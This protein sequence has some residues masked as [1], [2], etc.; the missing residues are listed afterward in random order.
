MTWLGAAEKLL[1]R[2]LMSLPNPVLGALAGPPHERDGQT[3]D[4]RVQLIIRSQTLRRRPQLQ[5]MLP[6][7]ARREYRHALS[8]LLEPVRPVAS[9]ED[10]IIDGVPVRIYTPSTVRGILVYMHGGGGVIGGLDT[11][12]APCRVLCDE[13]ECVVISVDYRLAPEDPHPSGLEDAKK[14]FSWA[15]HNAEQLGSEAD[16][17]A[18]GGDSFGGS[19]AALLGLHVRQEAGPKPATQLLLY[20]A[21]D[22]TRTGGS[23]DLFAQGYL[24]DKAL[25]AWFRDH[26]FTT[27][28]DRAAA[29]PLLVEEVGGMNPVI[30]MTAGFDPLRDEA[31]DY[32]ERL[33]S[34]GVPV[35]YHCEPSLVHAFISMTGVVPQADEALRRAA[36]LLKAR[37]ST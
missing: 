2:G 25:I 14:V 13:A 32:A 4:R 10:R 29:S 17:V 7:A 9:V 27:P 22:F 16:R 31:R 26:A 11:C 6:Q 23:R 34:A 5:D 19:L 36:H 3:L 20:P 18:V 1:A 33:R 30:V 21:C 28:E 15:V 37:L 35:D 12:D 8:L 24:L